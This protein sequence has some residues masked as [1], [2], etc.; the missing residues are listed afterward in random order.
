M[1]SG[2]GGHSGAGP[3]SAS[4]SMPLAV[5]F[6]DMPIERYYFAKATGT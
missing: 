2:C 6:P 5:A 3:G 1:E 4:R